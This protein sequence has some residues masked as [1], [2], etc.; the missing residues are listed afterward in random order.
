MCV[1]VCVSVSVTVSVVRVGAVAHK[2]RSNQHCTAP[3]VI[4]V[5]QTHVHLRFAR[6]ADHS[7]RGG[8]ATVTNTWWL[9]WLHGPA[10]WRGANVVGGDLPVMHAWK[11]PGD[12]D[13]RQAPAIHDLSL[14]GREAAFLSNAQASTSWEGGTNT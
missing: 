8:Y 9:F 2:V 12:L 5:S 10:D 6:M 11:V 4:C 7:I 14:Q 13:V 1:C 3:W